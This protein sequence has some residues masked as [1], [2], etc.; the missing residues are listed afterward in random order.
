MSDLILELFSE[1]IPAKMQLKA[2]K[3]VEEKFTEKLQKLGLNIKPE[4][5]ITPRRLV[6]TTKGI[7]KTIKSEAQ[8]IRGPRVSAGD[9][10]AAGFLRKCGLDSLDK[11]QKKAISGEEYYFFEQEAKESSI[12]RDLTS[13]LNGLVKD[14]AKFWPKTMRWSNYDIRWVRPLSNILCLLDDKVL[15]VEYG[16]LKANNKTKG[17]RFLGSGKEFV[18]N[19]LADYLDKLAKESVVL[20]QNERNKLI[21]EEL[22]K[23]CTAKKLSINEDPAL[24]DEVTG[25]VEYPVVLLGEINNEFMKLPE[26]VLITTLKNHQKYFCV[27]NSVGKLAPYFVF[28]SNNN[29]K[30]NEVVIEGNQRVLRARLEDAKFFYADDLKVKLADRVEDLEKIVFHKDIGTLREKSANDAVLAKFISVW[31]PNAHLVDIEVAATI[32][33]ADLTTEMVGEFPEL[34][35]VMGYYYALA[36]GLAADISRAVKNHY[37]PQGMKDNC[38]EEATSVSVALADKINSLVSLMLIGEKPTGS[39]DPYALRRAAIGVIRIILHNKL[40]I[41]LKLV[42]EKS[43]NNFPKLLKASK[44]YYPEINP[45]EF[46]KFIEL[47]ILEFIIDRFKILLKEDKIP[48][49][50]INAVFDSGELDDIQ[51][52]HEKSHFIND[53]IKT[54][55]GQKILESYRRAS[56]IYE[57]A[58]QEDGVSYFKRPHL[59]ALKHESE[60]KL[61]SVYK[62]I[63]SELPGLLKNDDYAEAFHKIA[64]FVDPIDE[65]FEQVVVNDNDSSLRQNRLKLLASLCKTV[66]TL[67]NFSKI[68]KTSN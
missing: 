58:E 15:A 54:E 19:G 34:Q 43:L 3:F 55:Q 1:E 41:P 64:E 57:K 60:K 49:D 32:A 7:P 66:N 28:V 44:K 35:G 53:I 17:H 31:V 4:V 18:V 51:K 22:D 27:R 46:K 11:L 61:F 33:K 10:A 68:E 50:I 67:A 37:L 30:K 45:K 21:R 26:E 36:E 5:Y 62:D 52:I 25:L 39:K 13:E 59:L 47:E 48:H 24:L 16:H 8:S 9:K 2:V 12:E 63:K 42:I 29:T 38:P 40:N 20:D 14:I 6:L 65:F 56:R 23:I